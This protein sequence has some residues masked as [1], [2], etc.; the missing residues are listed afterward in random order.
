MIQTGQTY[1]VGD[2]VH[3]ANATLPINRTRDYEI[4]AVHPYGI[5]M[6]A[7]G[8]SYFLTHDQAKRLGITHASKE[9]QP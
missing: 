4:T 3:F 2:I 1:E 7:I 6:T 8:H 9:Q 5:S